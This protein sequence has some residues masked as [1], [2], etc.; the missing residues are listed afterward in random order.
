MHHEETATLQKPRY[1]SENSFF[2]FFRLVS[3]VFLSLANRYMLRLRRCDGR[4]KQAA[5][6]GLMSN[7]WFSG[8][9]VCVCVCVTS[10][11]QHVA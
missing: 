11:W 2:L 5:V 9:P 1:G 8:T 3:T 6:E 7:R 4:L 10:L